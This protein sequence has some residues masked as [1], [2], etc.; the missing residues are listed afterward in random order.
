MSDK[1]PDS[2]GCRVYYDPNTQS[3]LT[4]EAAEPERLAAE[5]AK[6]ERLTVI[7]PIERERLAA[8]TVPDVGLTGSLPGGFTASTDMVAIILLQT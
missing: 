7:K 6:P 2:D 8:E 5:A 3:F 1:R 4:A